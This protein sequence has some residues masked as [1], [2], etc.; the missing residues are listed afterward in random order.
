MIFDIRY[1]LSSNFEKED[2]LDLANY[3]SQSIDNEPVTQEN[4]EGEIIAESKQFSIKVTSRHKS[5]TQYAKK[6]YSMSKNDKEMDFTDR[7]SLTKTSFHP[8]KSI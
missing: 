1:K 8:K 5:K 2:D 4:E 3:Q 7:R 6:F